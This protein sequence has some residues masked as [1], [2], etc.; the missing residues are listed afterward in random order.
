M[1]SAGEIQSG[2]PVSPNVSVVLPVGVRRACLALSA[3][4][5]IPPENTSSKE[6]ANATIFGRCFSSQNCDDG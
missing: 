3:A 5:R 6:L 2:E 1:E 4:N